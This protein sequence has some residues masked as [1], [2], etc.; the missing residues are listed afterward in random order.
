ME[1]G[2]SS[3]VLARFNTLHADAQSSD[4]ESKIV[5]TLFGIIKL[6]KD[7]QSVE[8]VQMKL[9]RVGIHPMNRSGKRMSATT[10]NCK[11]SKI[12]S[13]GVSK[14]LCNPERA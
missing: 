7:T 5:S 3:E 8:V 12:I 1:L 9:H 14:A 2:W 11:G 10:M 6:L 4:R 13:V